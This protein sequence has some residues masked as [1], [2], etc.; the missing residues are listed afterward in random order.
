MEEE[1]LKNVVANLLEICKFQARIKDIEN[2]QRISLTLLEMNRKEKI[3]KSISTI[4]KFWLK[5]KSKRREREEFISQRNKILQDSLKQN[6]E[7]KKKK[8]QL[9][10]E[11][12]L[13]LRRRNF[14]FV[15]KPTTKD[16]KPTESQSLKVEKIEKKINSK[17]KK[18]Q[19][20]KYQK[21]YNLELK[22]KG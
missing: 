22:F 1:K 17:R 18:I 2:F 12:K 15:T 14:C 7:I 21:L 11:A 16:F 3:K 4:E 20:Q 6:Q 13:D 8:E 19:I 10:L 5:I 9:E